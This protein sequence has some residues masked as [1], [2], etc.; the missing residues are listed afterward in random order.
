MCSDVDECSGAMNGCAAE[1]MCINAAGSFSCICRDGFDGDGTSCVDV[2]ECAS[3]LAGCHG[4]ATCTNTPG[5]FTCSCKPGYVGD[6]SDCTD[7]DECAAGGASCDPNATCSNTPGGFACACRSGFQG[8]GATCTDVDE[9][10][11][12]AASC[13]ANASCSNTPGS[14]GCACETGFSGDGVMCSDVDECTSGADNCDVNA[15]CTNTPGAFQCACNPGYAGNGVTCSETQQTCDLTG[16]FAMLT[17]TDVEWDAV[18]ISGITA[19]E[20]GSET[21]YAWSLRRQV[22]NDTSLAI[23]VQACGET[24][25]ELC[26]SILGQAITQRVPPATY[27]LA[28]MPRFASTLTLAE[29]AAAGGRFL[30]ALESYSIGLELSPADRAWPTAHDDPAITWRDQ[31]ADGQ[32]GVTAL[33]P[34]EGQSSRC[35]LPFGGLPILSSLE[36]ASRVYMGTRSLA[37]LDGTIVDCDLIRGTLLGAGGGLPRLE[38]HV[39][40]CLKADGQ[41]C[42]AEETESLDESVAGAERRVIAARFTLVRVAEASSCEQVRAL[43]FP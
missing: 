30:S 9:C 20:A 32:P 29:P 41:P 31:D 37:S 5:A 21:L 16:T 23:E 33:I 10:A 35:S 12:G 19:I 1:A 25:P 11:T 26:S 36:F 7:V 38:G 6:G 4:D 39:A 17:E 43:D 42:S 3:D 34:L 18:S 2:D 24:T 40:G 27:A 13:S 14:F 8:D 22:Q 28:S 15:S